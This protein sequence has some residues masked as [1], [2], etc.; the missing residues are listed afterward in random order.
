MVD[1]VT[2]PLSNVPITNSAGNIEPAFRSFT[3]KLALR[4]LIIGN[5]NPEGVIEGAQGAVY[6]NEDA[7]AGDVLFIKRLSDIGGDK[8]QGWRAV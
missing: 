3:Q 4:S 1:R 5:G 8:T 7:S 2:P 6:M